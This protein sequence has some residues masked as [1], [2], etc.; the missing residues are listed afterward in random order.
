MIVAITKIAILFHRS[1]SDFQ[2]Q[3]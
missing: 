3:N 2:T 1:E